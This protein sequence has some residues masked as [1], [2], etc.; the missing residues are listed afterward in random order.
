MRNNRFSVVPA[1]I[2]DSITLE[3]PTNIITVK[4][5]S[6]RANSTIVHTDDP[7]DDFSVVDKYKTLTITMIVEDMIPI[8]GL[9]N[10]GRDNKN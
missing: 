1:F 7:A 5:Y 6:I 2:K 10:E 4:D 9:E 8:K 3:F